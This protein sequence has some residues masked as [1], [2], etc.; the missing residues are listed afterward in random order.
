M[1]SLW[2]L[3]A[4]EPES[5]Q[6]EAWRILWLAHIAPLVNLNMSCVHVFRD[7]FLSTSVPLIKLQ[8][9]LKT[10][11][12]YGLGSSTIWHQCLRRHCPSSRMKS[13][14]ITG[15]LWLCLPGITILLC[16]LIIPFWCHLLQIH[17][18]WSGYLTLYTKIHQIN[19]IKLLF[20]SITVV[21]RYS[22]KINK[23]K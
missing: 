15:A 22:F 21:Q 4:G 10:A 23:N 2:R 8:A 11:N 18:F 19:W 1:C 9:A 5:S 16:V 17:R 6:W 3:G 14:K 13:F 7:K 12:I 20:Q